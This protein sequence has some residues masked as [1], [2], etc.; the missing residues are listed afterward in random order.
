MLKTAPNK[1]KAP[2]KLPTADVT[3]KQ[4]VVDADVEDFKPDIEIN[5]EVISS[6]RHVNDSVVLELIRRL[7]IDNIK[8]S[9]ITGTLNPNRKSQVTDVPDAESFTLDDDD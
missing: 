5:I 8:E 7:Y 6:S 3:I 4:S 9:T 1:T 2:E